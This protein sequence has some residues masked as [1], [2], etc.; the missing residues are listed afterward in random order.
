VVVGLFVPG[1]VPYALLDV[2]GLGAARYHHEQ[3]QRTADVLAARARGA[4]EV[5]TRNIEHRPKSL[6]VDDLT[7]D[8]TDWRNVWFASYFGVK[9][10][11]A[12][13]RRGGRAA[14]VAAAA[15]PASFSARPAGSRLAGRGPGRRPG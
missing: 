14:P 5:V 11:V 7:A 1:N 2:F 12:V 3:V 10:V 15:A 6:W 4:S 8:A 9:S 13:D